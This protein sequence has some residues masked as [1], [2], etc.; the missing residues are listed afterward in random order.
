MEPSERMVD[1]G[2]F[3]VRNLLCFWGAEFF[4]V[5]QRFHTQSHGVS[6]SQELEIRAMPSNGASP[7]D[8]Q[9]HLKAVD[10]LQEV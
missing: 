6:S 7:K 9:S 4:Q 2:G 3:Q 10:C 8:A 5:E 1:D